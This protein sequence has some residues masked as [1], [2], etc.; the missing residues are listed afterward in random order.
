MLR[1]VLPIHNARPESTIATAAKSAPAESSA[2]EPA[3]RGTDTEILA[4]RNSTPRISVGEIRTVDLVREISTDIVRIVFAAARK[5]ESANSGSA[6][7]ARGFV[8]RRGEADEQIGQ[9]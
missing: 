8:I 2:S 6:N 4:A 3:I 7:N 9:L 1:V 5:S